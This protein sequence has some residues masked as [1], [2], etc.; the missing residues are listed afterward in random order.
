MKK[1]YINLPYYI[2]KRIYGNDKKDDRLSRP[3]VVIAM[4]GIALGLAVM[5]I[6]VFIVIGFKSEIRNKM[7]GVSSAINITNIGGGDSRQMLAINKA[8]SLMNV[9][10]KVDGVRNVQRYSLAQGIIKTDESFNGVMLKGVGQEFDTLFFSKHIV[11]GR[12]PFLNDTVSSREVIISKMIAKKMKLKVGDRV[13]SYHISNS[14]RG[15]KFTVV[16]IYDTNLAE[17]DDKFIITDLYTVNRLNGFNGKSAGGIEINVPSFEDIDRVHTAVS[18]LIYNSDSED[19]IYSVVSVTQ[20]S[21]Q[22]FDWLELLDIN[23]WVILALM[24]GVSG[25]TM[26]SGL[27]IIII[28]RTQM[29]GLMKSL[30]ADNQTI[31]HTFLWLSVFIIGKSMAIGNIIALTLCVV[32][33]RFHIIK[34]NPDTYYIDNVPIEFDLLAFI[35]INII[36]F[37][38]SLAMLLIPSFIVSKIEPATSMR[39]E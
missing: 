21:P 12:M 11:E 8:D 26:I 33:E 28:E 31:R 2:A 13:E 14:V 7:L 15:R 27:L 16:G 6:S 23:V 22:I 4:G 30:G 1:D 18:E 24:I 36:S 37:I 35:G 32:Q 5:I 20:S 29:I 39:Y 10:R 3:A 17:F 25:F 9:I 38:C 34:L 19:E